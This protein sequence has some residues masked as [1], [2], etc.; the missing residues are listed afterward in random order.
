MTVTALGRTGPRRL[1]TPLTD[2]PY[3]D[4]PLPARALRSVEDAMDG[5]LAL[6]FLLPSGL[7]AEPQPAYLHLVSAPAPRQPLHADDEGRDRATARA[8]LPSPSLSAARLVQAVLEVLAGERPASQLVR[9]TDAEI[10]AWLQRRVA[11]AP[12]PRP[13]AA[14]PRHRAVLRSLRVCE[15][16]DGVAEATAVVRRGPRTSAVALR[17]EGLDGRWQCTALEFG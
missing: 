9:W 1:P 2:P 17:L 8:C 13:T 3:D 7:P 6:D 4:S 5:T 15:P 12:R 10:Y 16:A 14:T 11:A